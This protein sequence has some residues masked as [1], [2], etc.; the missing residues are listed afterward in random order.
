MLPGGNNY[1]EELAMTTI[2]ATKINLPLP[3]IDLRE[4]ERLQPLCAQLVCGVAK[5]DPDYIAIARQVIHLISEVAGMLE[6][7]M[8]LPER[9]R[10]NTYEM[11]ESIAGARAVAD[12]I[13]FVVDEECDPLPADQL[14][15]G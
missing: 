12:L 11:V 5:H 14:T 9:M 2:E 3:T 10:S 4:I 1:T 7:R 6:E 15:F 13:A 8:G